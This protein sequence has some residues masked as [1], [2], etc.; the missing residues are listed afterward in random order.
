LP[1]TETLFGLATAGLVGD[2]GFGEG[3]SGFKASLFFFFFFV[4]DWRGG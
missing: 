3:A 1:V 4:L 2:K